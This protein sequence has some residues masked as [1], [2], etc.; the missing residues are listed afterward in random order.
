M[1]ADLEAVGGKE[2]NVKRIA[3]APLGGGSCMKSVA[4]WLVGW[5]VRCQSQA[6]GSKI[7]GG[8]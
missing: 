2:G 6:Q 8:A 1:V 4:P 3:K 5:Q 7:S